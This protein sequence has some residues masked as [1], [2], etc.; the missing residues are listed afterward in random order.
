MIITIV[1]I[2]RITIVYLIIMNNILLIILMLFPM[3]SSTN[4]YYC[5]FHWIKK[6]N[7]LNYLIWLFRKKRKIQASKKTKMYIKVLINQL[8]KYLNSKINIIVIIYKIMETQ[9]IISNHFWDNSSNNNNNYQYLK[10]P[11]CR[12]VRV[13]LLNYSDE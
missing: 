10:D 3:V 1:S 11:P 6:Y 8:D 4:H 13:H 12:L 9:E 7:H 2:K 5:I